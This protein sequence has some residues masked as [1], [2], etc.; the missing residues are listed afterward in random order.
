MTTTEIYKWLQ[1]ELRNIGDKL[2]N[3][4]EHAVKDIAS[5]KK[6]QAEMKTDVATTKA[7]I[8]WIKWL[9]GAMV[10]AVIGGAIRLWFP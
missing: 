4:I 1:Q 7:D 10:L 8:G 6:D 3:H 5:I 9:L 2:D